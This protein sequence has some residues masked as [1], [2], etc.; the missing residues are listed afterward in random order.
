MRGL[1]CTFLLLFLFGCK[2]E[3]VKNY[4]QDDVRGYWEMFNARRDGK[5]TKTLNGAWI[6]IH[7]NEMKDNFFTNEIAY[8]I[9]IDGNNL[10][11][12]SNP[13]REYIIEFASK[14]TLRLA[15]VHNDLKFQFELKKLLD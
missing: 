4:T 14:D 6:K 1:L 13:P 11:H 15:T 8:E 9:K 7:E 3:P 2:E 12:L 5:V 10:T